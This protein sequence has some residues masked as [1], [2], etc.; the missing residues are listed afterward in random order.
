MIEKFKILDGIYDDKVTTGLFRLIESS[1]TRG[2][3]SK[4]WCTRGVRKYSFTNKV[5]SRLMEQPS[6]KDCNIKN[7]API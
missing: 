6:R 5:R 4:Q 2:K 1:V 7:G 3:F